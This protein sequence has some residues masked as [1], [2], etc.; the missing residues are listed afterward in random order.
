[1]I[2]E[3]FNALFRNHI[4]ECLLRDDHLCYIRNAD[5][6]IIMSAFIYLITFTILR[7]KYRFCKKHPANFD[8]EICRVLADTNGLA[9]NSNQKI[10]FFHSRENR[11]LLVSQDSIVLMIAYSK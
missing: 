5:K 6:C 2:D 11:D 9:L 7:V 4:L 3:P 10:Y 8:A 1:M